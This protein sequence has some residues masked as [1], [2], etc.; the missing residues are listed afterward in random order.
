MPESAQI[1]TNWPDCH[2]QMGE[3]PVSIQ[4]P[5]YTEYDGNSNPTHLSY[6]VE[7]RNSIV[8]WWCHRKM[9]S[10]HY[11]LFIERYVTRSLSANT[12]MPEPGVHA[13]NSVAHQCHSILQSKHQGTHVRQPIP[14]HCKS[15]C[16]WPA[17]V[18]HSSKNSHM[19]IIVCHRITQ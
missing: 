9:Y 6:C 8:S 2:T 1:E 10:Y 18:N 15:K 11:I 14:K 5:I 12:R 7:I 4:Q 19:I 16:H 3:G 13:I 17:I